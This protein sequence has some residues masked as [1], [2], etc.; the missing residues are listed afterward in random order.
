MPGISVQYVQK[1]TGLY[2]L[3]FG[4]SEFCSCSFAALIPNGTEIT[5]KIGVILIIVVKIGANDQ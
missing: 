1:E 4:K 5:F 2:V 3:N